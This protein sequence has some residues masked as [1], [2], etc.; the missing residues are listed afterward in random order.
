MK[1]V[2][3][4]LLI[5]ATGSAIEWADLLVK[6]TRLGEDPSH[7]NSFFQ[8][9]RTKFDAINDSWVEVTGLTSLNLTVYCYEEGDGR[10]CLEYDSYGNIAGIQAAV[11][12]SDVENVQSIYNRS[13]LNQFQIKTIF[14][15]EYWTSTIYFIS[16]ETIAAGGRSEMNGL[17]GTE[18]IWIRTTDGFIEIPRNV[19]EWDSAWTK[20][21]CVSEQGIHYVYALNRSMDCTNLYPWFLMEQGGELSGFGFQ[22]FGKTTYKN[23]NWYETIIPRFIRDVAPTLPQCIIDWGEDYGFICM[24]VLL[25]STPWTYVCP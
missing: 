2:A 5:A 1:V 20:E 12:C 9:P 4:L 25:T 22:G 6:W 13:N 11:L 24:H 10:V 14:D 23:R 3:V 16:P 17:T 7:A 21:A 19:S 8:M 18:G 15:E